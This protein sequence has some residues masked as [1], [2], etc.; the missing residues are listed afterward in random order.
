MPVQH[1]PGRFLPGIGEEHG[2]VG[3]HAK[4]KKILAVPVP[5]HKL[6]TI[7]QIGVL[8]VDWHGVSRPDL[9]LSG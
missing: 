1:G 2:Q 9:P 8:W 4:P 5:I 3:A 6:D 7:N